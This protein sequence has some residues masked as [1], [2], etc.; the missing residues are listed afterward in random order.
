MSFLLLNRINI[1]RYNPCK[2]KFPG[3][4][5]NFEEYKEILKL[6]N[7]KIDA[8]SCQLL[9]LLLISVEPEMPLLLG[10]PLFLSPA[11]QNPHA[12]GD[13]VP[14][15]WEAGRQPTAGL[16]STW[17]SLWVFK[18][19][20]SLNTPPPQPLSPTKSLSLLG[21]RLQSSRV[22]KT[23]GQSFS[24]QR[25]PPRTLSWAL[26]PVP[27]LSRPVEEVFPPRSELE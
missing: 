15:V 6:E 27:R 11:G 9:L 12:L 2:Q 4:L 21:F 18:K 3:A 1:G 10:L 26:T 23:P 22:G 24:R 25:T 20:T 8:P 5:N 13:P 7:L 17:C 19:A 16:G 14:G